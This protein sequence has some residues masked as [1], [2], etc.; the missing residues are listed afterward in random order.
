MVDGDVDMQAVEALA[1][2]L[3]G[4]EWSTRLYF[5]TSNPGNL[6]G[7]KTKWNGERLE[8]IKFLDVTTSMLPSGIPFPVIPESTEIMNVIVPDML[9]NALTEK[10]TVDEACEDAARRV[11]EL[12]GGI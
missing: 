5:A 2:V 11:E 1:C 6:R 8:Q 9:Q 7:F 4:P 3:T 12:L 10:M